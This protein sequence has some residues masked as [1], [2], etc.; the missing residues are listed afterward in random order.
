VNLLANPGFEDG[1]TGWE[2]P[3]WF[4]S[5]S[6]VQS[7]VRYSG[8]NAFYFHNKTNG[9]Y[10]SQVIPAHVGQTVTYSVWVNS[11]YHTP[12]WRNTGHVHMKLE[13][14]TSSKGTI[15]IY[16]LRDELGEHFLLPNTLGEWFHDVRTQVLPANTAYV[17]LL[18]DT[19]NLDGWAYLDDAS[20]TISGP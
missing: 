5:V 9:P 2:R 4:A 10:T 19:Y 11:V 7:G 8:N 16:P 15:A 3:D 6:E 14:L 17:R 13:A 1:I 20:L 18:F 12:N